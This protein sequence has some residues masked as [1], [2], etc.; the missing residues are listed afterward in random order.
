M[1]KTFQR[2]VALLE[3]VQ[4]DEGIVYDQMSKLGHCPNDRAIVCACR[5]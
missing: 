5:S 1:R 2:R 4:S 3:R